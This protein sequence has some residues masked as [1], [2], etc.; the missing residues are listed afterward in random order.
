[1]LGS[2]LNLPGFQAGGA[3]ANPL[4]ASADFRVNGTKVH[5]PAPAS[6]I[7]SVTHLVSELRTLAAD[8]TNLCHVRDSRFVDSEELRRLQSFEVKVRFYSNIQVSRKYGR[9]NRECVTPELRR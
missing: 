2:F 1:M 4:V 6:H 9:I 5:V 8:I 7:V 3:D